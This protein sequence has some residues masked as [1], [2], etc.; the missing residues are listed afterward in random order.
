MGKFVNPFTDIGFKVIF[1][2]E[3]S[4][5]MLI[6]FLN[7]LL[8]GEYEVTDLTF[9]DKED[10]GGN[11]NDRGIVYDI[12]C[13]TSDGKYII[14][15]MQNRW[16]SHFLDRTLYYVCR[17][18]S[19][20]NGQNAYPKSLGDDRC[21]DYGKRY[22]LSAVYGIFLMNFKEEGLEPKF[23]SDTTIIDRDT[24]KAINTHFRQIYLQFPFFTKELHECG[25][26]FEKWLYTLKNMDKWNRMPD[27]LKEQVFQRLAQLAEVANLSEDNRIAYDKALD[28]YYIDETVRYDEYMRAEKA[29]KDMEETL[30]KGRKEGLEKGRKEGMEEGRKEGMEEGI[31]KVAIQ[32]LKEGLTSD[33]ISQCTGLTAAEIATLN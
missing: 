18:I 27:A 28:Y 5:D 13:R 7:G 31:R 15:E 9:L 2:S 21:R 33:V 3:P 12:Y 23:R 6:F 24:G 4:K 1:G 16:H 29:K 25:T 20:Q 8:E 17:G 22:D 11:V 26:L 19:R 10:H 30:A 32:M 14:V